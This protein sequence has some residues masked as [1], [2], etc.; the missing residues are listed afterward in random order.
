M[1][2][3][4]A[5]GSSV[6]VLSAFVW[7]T[8]YIFLHM[9]GTLSYFSV[10]LYP[11]LVGGILFLVYGAV[12][13]GHFSLPSRKLDIVLPALGYLSSQFMIIFS[14]EI[15]GGVITA[16]FVLIGDAILS[17]AIIYS[18]GR[19]RFVPNFSLFFP[20]I[21]ILVI[22]SA[23]LSLFGGQFGVHSLYG[24]LLVSIVPVLI[25]VFFV[26]TNERIMVD[27]MARIL[28]PTFF[29]SSAIVILPALL[30]HDPV[31]LMI[32]NFSD[33]LILFVIGATSMFA[34]Y[35]LFF[36]ASKLTGFTLTS[37]LMCMIPVFTLLLSVS[38]IGFSLT[39]V[40]VALVIGA[41][42]GATMCTIAFGE[43]KKK[44]RSLA[45]R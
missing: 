43:G 21:A 9:L 11:S 20:G 33:M 39:P 37:I 5:A 8:Y 23:T 10:F 34:G 19:N 14:T 1:K 16:T 32:P 45:S 29:A 3:E 2:R 42:S 31:A 35:L 30:I 4:V 22:S 7:S 40:S 27:G 26:Y 17:P 6:A 12:K 36:A 13:G 28:T 41:V 18:I 44:D 25:A 24:L 15:N 38:L